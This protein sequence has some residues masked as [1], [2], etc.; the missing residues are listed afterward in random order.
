M[1]GPLNTDW[2]VGTL[3]FLIHFYSRRAGQ[4]ER[5]KKS[6][7]RRAGQEERVEGI[8]PSSEAWEAPALPLSYT[9]IT[10]TVKKFKKYTLLLYH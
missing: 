8:E 4:E 9:R 6:G 7:S 10:N 3:V 1:L 2:N 5:V